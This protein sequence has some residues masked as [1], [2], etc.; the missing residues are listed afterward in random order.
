MAAPVPLQP[1]SHSPFRGIAWPRAVTGH[2]VSR[3][4][5]T[6][7]TD[8]QNQRI[9]GAVLW[10]A[11]AVALYVSVRH[12]LIA[13]PDHG[14]LGHVSGAWTALAMD[15]ADGTLYRPLCAETGYG[16]TR[17]FP[18]HFV[19]QGL[20]IRAGVSA[21]LAG[22][23]IGLGAML[24]LVTGAHRLMRSLGVPARL[25]V[26]F[27][28]LVLSPMASQHALTAI[29]GDGLAAA[30]N[31]W[32]LAC[33]AP[34]FASPSRRPSLLA[35]AVLFSLAFATKVTTVFGFAAAVA[36][37]SFAREWKA[38]G[39][40]ALFTL[41]GMVVVLAATQLASGGRAWGIMSACASGGTN[42]YYVTTA[43]RRLFETVVATDHQSLI[44]LVLSIAALLSV[45]PSQW[46]DLAALS[47]I[48]SLCVLS[49]IMGSPGTD[50]NH[51]IDVA[52]L[53]L[54]FI[55]VQVARQQLRIA[56]AAAVGVSA[57]CILLSWT[58]PQRILRQGEAH[59][60]RAAAVQVVREASSTGL[61]VLCESPLLP[62]LAGTRPYM[63]DPF[64]FRLI[65]RKS[66][67]VAERMRQQLRQGYFSAVVL[68]TDPL[69]E[70]GERRLKNVHFGRKFIDGLLHSYQESERHG[71]YI[72]FRPK[73]RPPHEG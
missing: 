33:C 70:G 47:L 57:I 51:F 68:Q 26:P 43:P 61:P 27:A 22:Y 38:A 41:A 5:G 44:L 1:C 29:R 12:V 39:R 2:R 65:S 32:A 14:G 17:F 54:V 21:L 73:R 18:L 11:A 30:L 31:I 46:K 67:E 6:H 59:S 34:A 42:W 63:L 4:L 64:M 37:F 48:T 71:R 20:L 52:V 9:P 62:I 28:L 15:L 36:A 50:F 56:F 35:G 16:G 49:V 69:T 3:T 19:L 60:G 25:A 23:L 8:L 66:P 24:A 45:R 10:L 40:L 13:L 58:L 53:A 55:A 72:I 7:L